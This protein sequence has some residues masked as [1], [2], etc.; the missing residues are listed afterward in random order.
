M[1]KL[2]V[3]NCCRLDEW[4]MLPVVLTTIE[5][6]LLERSFSVHATKTPYAWVV[7][8]HGK[9]FALD[10]AGDEISFAELIAD[11]PGIESALTDCGGGV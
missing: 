7:V 10:P 11:V 6:T 3:G 8:G 1:R 2:E 9:R 4:A 5:E